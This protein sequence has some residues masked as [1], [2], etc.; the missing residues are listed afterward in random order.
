MLF[1]CLHSIFS[2]FS[3]CLLWSLFTRTLK[4]V[5]SY[6]HTHKVSLAAAP[7][8]DAPANFAWCHNTSRPTFYIPFSMC[9]DDRQ[10]M[11]LCCSIYRREVESPCVQ[12]HQQICHKTQE[13]SRPLC[14]E[15]T[16]IHTHVRQVEKI[17]KHFPW[18]SYNCFPEKISRNWSNAMFS[19]S[20]KDS[21]SSK[22]VCS[23]STL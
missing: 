13:I 19:F 22:T 14:T 17:L 12:Y 16:I 11:L 5:E 1:N 10:W 20:C 23:I 15:Y 4:K 9:I 6:Y 8:P 2:N 3:K 7:L 21:L 18:N